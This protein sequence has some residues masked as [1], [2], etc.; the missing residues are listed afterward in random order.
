M[1][2]WKLWIFCYWLTSGSVSFFSYKSLYKIRP[3]RAESIKAIKKWKQNPRPFI[4]ICSTLDSDE[5]GYLDLREFLLAIELVAAR[6]PE[7]K[8]IWAFRQYDND[9]SSQLDQKEMTKGQFPIQNITEGS[10]WIRGAS[11]RIYL[12]KILIESPF[13][14]MCLI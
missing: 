1:F 9:N 3:F 7:E 12:S 13:F 6:T 5:S 14:G 2:G 4:Y 8:L 11:H 10:H